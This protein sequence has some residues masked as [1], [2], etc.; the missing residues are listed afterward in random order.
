MINGA[1]LHLLFAKDATHPL[2]YYAVVRKGF[3]PLRTVNGT[4][5]RSVQYTAYGAKLRTVQYEEELRSSEYRAHYVQGAT[6]LVL[7]SLIESSTKHE[8]SIQSEALYA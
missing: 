3:Q 4:E 8:R 7:R 5:L 6:L 2:L 1:T